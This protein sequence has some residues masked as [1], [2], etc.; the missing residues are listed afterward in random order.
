VRIAIVKTSTG[1][2][3]SLGS[4]TIIDGGP[5]APIGQVLSAAHVFVDLEQTLRPRWDPMIVDDWGATSAPVVIMIGLYEGDKLPSR[6]AY[7]A[8]LVT[9]LETLKASFQDAAPG[10]ASFLDLAVLRIRGRLDATPSVFRWYNEVYTA[11]QKHAPNT[12]DEQQA[13]QALP[14]GIRLGDPTTLETGRSMVTVFG[15]FT[16]VPDQSGEMTLHVPQAYKVMAMQPH[17]LLCTQALLNT[18]GSGGGMIDF[19]GRL[20]A[21]NSHS[22]EPALPLPKKYRAY[23]RMVSELSP[24]HQLIADRD[25]IAEAVQEGE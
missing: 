8:E 19:N 13:L 4:G 20:V 22:T 1:G 23:G 6:W 24:A 14:K 9:P 15:W 7:W 11:I 17:G 5:A 18:S 25:P 12:T 2:I 3:I 21:V 10:P 16:T